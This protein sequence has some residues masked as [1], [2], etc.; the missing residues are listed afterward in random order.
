MK[1]K[2]PAISL[3]LV[4]LVTAAAGM[5]YFF[6]YQPA[7][8]LIKSHTYAGREACRVCHQLQDSLWQSSHHS[9]SMEAADSSTILGNFNNSS[10]TFFGS[11]SRFYKKTGKFYVYTE[12]GDGKMEEFEIKYTFGFT[13]LQQYLIEFPGGRLQCLGIAWDDIKKEW[14]LLYP[15]E[16]IN[17]DDWLHWTKAGQTWNL[18]CADCHSTNLI[19]NYNPNSDTYNTR[20]SEIDVSCEACHGASSGHVGWE[21]AGALVKWLLADSINKRYGLPFNSQGEATVV[22]TMRCGRCH[23]RRHRLTS[24]YQHNG[25]F[26]EHFIPSL[27]EEGL[28]FPDGQILDEVY[29]YGSFLQTK[30]HHNGV[31]CSNCHDVH[32][33]ALK[34]NN[35]ELC[36]SCHVR[37]KYDAKA[38]HFHPMGTESAL[39]INCHMTGRTYMG[40]DFRRDHS[41]RMP[42]P[43]LTVKL[44]VPNACTG[45]HHD[46]S[47]EWAV[48]WVIKWYGAERQNHFA[49]IISA[50]QT[51][52]PEFLPKVIQLVGDTS[53][54]VVVR[55]TALN[56]LNNYSLRQED[57]LVLEKA[58]KDK[59]ALIRVTGLRLMENF[60]LSR[61]IELVAPLLTD[62]VRGVRIQA[63]L[64]MAD[65]AISSLSEEQLKSLKY[66]LEELEVSLQLNE[67][68]PDGQMAIALHRYKQKDYHS[69]M[70][71]YQ[72]A[73]RLDGKF[74]QARMNL[75]NLYNQMGMNREAEQEF[76]EIIRILPNF[77]EAYYSLGLLFAEQ[78][79]LENAVTYLELAAKKMPERSRVHYNY[80]LAL[81]R[82]KRMEQAEKSLQKAL[83]LEPLSGDYLKALAILYFQK[84]D[85]N[86]AL[87]HTDKFVKLFPQMQEPKKLLEHIKRQ[88][89]R[90]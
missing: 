58:V 48:D 42:R 65:V 33:T 36:V 10:V 76:K 45:C 54:P 74:I 23:A 50:G 56:L 44:G 26:E 35:N 20:W 8:S 5:Y 29:V 18:M 72:S 11:T 60:P 6:L 64:V 39:C 15:N 83:N 87:L 75:A 2:K 25:D 78:N 41:F 1:S 16:D 89:K 27:L 62:T 3:I 19:K 4:L 31:K 14:Y 52:K 55:A 84:K 57:I 68:F 77:G 85:W 66:A 12:G 61:K 9:R 7:V 34:R 80:G 38:H 69:A 63:A 79:N 24:R 81:Q 22:E 53:Y 43:D 47:A 30:M 67:D 28:Y 71:A 21:D 49:E 40:I 82:L 86:K 32:S 13:P 17:H 46:K 51:G 73:I 90:N 59:N 37:S 70:E 88:M